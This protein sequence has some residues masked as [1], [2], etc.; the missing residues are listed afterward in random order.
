MSQEVPTI[1]P[2][3]PELP[4]L[5]DKAG[6]FY[7]APP[8]RHT[9]DRVYVRLSEQGWSVTF[10]HDGVM[11]VA[12]GAAQLRPLLRALEPLMSEPEL[13]AAAAVF[14]EGGGVPDIGT[15]LDA[16]PLAVWTARAEH[17]WLLRVIEREQV[18]IHYQP[19]V[20]AQ[21]SEQVYGYE[22]LL[23]GYADDGTQISPGRLFRTAEV[24]DLEFHLDRMA[25]VA[26]IRESHRLGVRANLFIN[27]RPTAIYDPEFCLRT[28][29]G[30][31][32]K[33]GIDPEQVVF[34]V[35]ESEAISD[36]AHL[37]HIV[38]EYRQGGFRIALDDLGAGYGSLN[39]LKDLEPDFIKLDRDLVRNVHHNPAQGTIVEAILSMA[40]NLG[41][42]SIGEGVEEAEEVQWLREAGA[43][44]LQGFYFARPAHPP[45]AL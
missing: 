13:A 21:A 15:L 41:V 40:R 8:L 31:V 16:R 28:T 26:A 38:D 10:P 14:L 5:S 39:L 23:R 6:V 32:E 2:G 33:L 19:I 1:C 11:G 22:C 20:Q 34:E 29:V 4:G 3:S 35:V 27:F 24:A 43:D 25:R 37:R 18:Q 42:T 36:H 45:P 17:D 12:V 30:A 9:R 44:L 7:L